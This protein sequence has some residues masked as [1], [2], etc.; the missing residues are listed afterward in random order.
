MTLSKKTNDYLISE[1]L[2]KK[3]ERS[4]DLESLLW[5]FARCNYSA[6]DAKVVEPFTN[7]IGE[8]R[9]KIVEGFRSRT[10]DKRT[11]EVRVGP[12]DLIFY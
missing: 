4:C 1:L 9:F 2:A 5:D 7:R 8:L 11:F 12:K 6:L 3:A 10:F